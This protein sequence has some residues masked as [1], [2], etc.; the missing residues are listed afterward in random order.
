MKE[1]INP[2]SFPILYVETNTEGEFWV[3]GNI[4]TMKKPT[5]L[6]RPFKQTLYEEALTEVINLQEG[7]I[8]KTFC[9]L[10]PDREKALYL[11]KGTRVSLIDVKGKKAVISVREGEPVNPKTIIAHTITTSGSSRTIRA[12]TH[13]IVVFIGVVSHKNPENYLVAIAGEEDVKILERGD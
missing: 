2:Y 12:G 1:K 13:G 8:L 4:F 5:G 10:L 9:V 11:K 7:R 6:C 3:C